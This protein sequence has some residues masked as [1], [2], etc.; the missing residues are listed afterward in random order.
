[1]AAPPP[2]KNAVIGYR[3]AVKADARRIAELYSIASDGISDYIWSKQAGAND[4]LLDVGQKRYERRNTAF[5]YE[6][7][8]VAEAA[9]KVVAVMLT[10]EMQEDDYVETDP[11]L[12]PFWLLEEVNS[13]YIAGIAVDTEWR[14]RGIA[15]TLMQMAEDKCRDKGLTRLSLIVLENNTIA[16]ELYKRLGYREVM[17]KTI[18]PH[19]LI[20]YTGDAL[21]MVK[22]L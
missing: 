2:D 5:S 8:L 16:Y 9:G 15:R 20:H 18:V 11:V 13:F 19:P 3:P 1:M 14:Q 10:Y 6:N 12:K 21:L 17:R 22:F 7:C 4:N